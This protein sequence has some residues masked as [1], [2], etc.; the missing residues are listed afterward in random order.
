[1]RSEPWTISLTA[2]DAFSE[3]TDR[4]MEFADREGRLLA[5]QNPAT[6]PSSIC[7]VRASSEDG[8]SWERILS[9]GGGCSSANDRSALVLDAA[10]FVAI[11]D[12]VVAL[13]IDRGDVAWTRAADAATVFGLHTTLRR[14]ALIVHGEL[15]ISRW[16]PGG[17][18]EWERSGRDIFTGGLSVTPA[19]IEV[20][21]FNDGR[22]LLSEAGEILAG[23]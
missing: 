13:R 22:Y 7:A 4:Q 1:M 17:V 2:L 3:A 15:A 8:R 11:G 9:A 23:P 6:R 20:F 14:E 5:L 21:D 18:R 10:L 19:G 12:S 16:T